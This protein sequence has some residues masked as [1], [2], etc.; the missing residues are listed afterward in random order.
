MR[1]APVALATL[2]LLAPASAAVAAPGG[3]D[4]PTPYTVTAQGLTLPDG[5]TFASGDHVNVRFTVDGESHQKNLHIEALNNQPSAKYVGT[6]YLPWQD[7]TGTDAY[8]ITWVQVGPYNEHFGEGG[9]EP[10]CTEDVPADAPPAGESPKPDPNAAPPK[11]E[12]P[13]GGSPSENPAPLASTPAAPSASG[14]SPSASGSPVSAA[15]PSPSASPAV[16]EGSG[17]PLASTGATALPLLLGAG[18]LILGGAALVV[19]RLRAR[20]A[21]GT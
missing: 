11:P 10:V 2:L 7:L 18:A 20:R 4:D 15:V 19:F 1:T 12:T 14:A 21:S 16:A 8:C 13:A 5:D 6:S 9:Q 3:S 17:G